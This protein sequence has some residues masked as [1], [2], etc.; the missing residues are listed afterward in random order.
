[1][2]KFTPLQWK[3]VFD[4]LDRDEARFH[5]PRRRRDSVV[6]ASFNIRKLGKTAKRSDGA[7]ELLRRFAERCDLLA[8]QEVNDNL[9]GL[10]HL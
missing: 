9:E 7:W 10:I 2:P 5:M 1:M 3:K 4:L 8:I 6:L